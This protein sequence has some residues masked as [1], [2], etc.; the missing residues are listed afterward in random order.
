MKAV[1]NTTTN[2]IYNNS[3]NTNNN[4]NTNN[5]TSIN[6]NLSGF[7]EAKDD[8]IKNDCRRYLLEGASRPIP[9]GMSG[10][11]A[12]DRAITEGGGR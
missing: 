7:Q 8:D 11:R 3:T 10:H 5:T 4:F 1:E 9:Q 6:N 12:M 2:N